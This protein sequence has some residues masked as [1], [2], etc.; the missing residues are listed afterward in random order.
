MKEG[1]VLLDLMFIKSMSG[2]YLCICWH[3]ILQAL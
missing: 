1:A 3:S 2:T